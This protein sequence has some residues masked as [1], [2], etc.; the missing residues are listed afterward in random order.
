MTTR[1][2]AL[3]VYS[4]ARTDNIANA[5]STN[6]RRPHETASFPLMRAAGIITNCAAKMQADMLKPAVPGLSSATY[7]PANG[8]RAAFARCQNMRAQQKPAMRLLVITTRSGT[9]RL[10][11]GSDAL[12]LR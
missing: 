12:A 1:G 2:C 7:W 11:K 8:H 9:A 5:A 10:L 4:K 6:G 3:S